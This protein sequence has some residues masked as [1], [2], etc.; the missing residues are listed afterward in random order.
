MHTC[1]GTCTHIYTAGWYRPGIRSPEKEAFL[2]MARDPLCTPQP[3]RDFTLGA[4]L[5]PGLQ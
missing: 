1:T 4:F 2:L 5:L 3:H